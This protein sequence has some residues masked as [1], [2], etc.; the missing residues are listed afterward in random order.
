M[1]SSIAISLLY[2]LPLLAETE[3]DAWKKRLEKDNIVIYT[4][5]LPDTKYLEFRAETEV[6]GSISRF[7][8]IITDFDN[9]EELLADCKS[10]D[11]IE[12]PSPDQFVYHMELSVPFPFAER[13]I[14]QLLAIEETDKQLNIRLDNLPEKIETQENVVRMQRASGSWVVKQI[15]GDK[16]YIN[17]QYFADPGGNIPPWLV[18]SFIVKSP[19]KTLQTIREKMES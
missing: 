9:Y 8:E 12:T 3:K 16:I 10:I 2:F 13:D 6:I 19:F 15:S 1:F 17:F 7:K 18:N 11:V 4:R 5:Q 14:V